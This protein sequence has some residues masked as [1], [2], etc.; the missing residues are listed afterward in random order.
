MNDK[1]KKDMSVEDINLLTNIMKPR[2]DRPGY[3]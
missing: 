3:I 1:H 2:L